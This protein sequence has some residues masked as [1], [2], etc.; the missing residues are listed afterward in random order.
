[1]KNLLARF[2]KLR[3]VS[4]L[5]ALGLIS[6][7]VVTL[8]ASKAALKLASE[9]QQVT[10]ASQKDKRPNRLIE[11]KS[12]YLLQHAYNPVDWFPWGEEAFEKARK[13]NK[14]IFL[15]IGYSTCFWCHQM[16]RHVFENED[17]AAMMNRY[18]VSIKVDREERPDVDRVYMSALQA[19]TGGGGWPMSMFLTP[20]LKPFYGATYIPPEQFRKLIDKIYE[21]WTTDPESIRQ[22]S[23]R[24]TESLKQQTGAEGD[25]VALEKSIGA[26]GFD[27]FRQTYDRQYAGFGKGPKFPHPA[28]FN[29]LLRYYYRFGEKEALQMTLQTLRRMAES[30]MY[31]HIGGG[32][33]RYSVDGQWRVP[34]FE[35]ML[36]DQ[37]QLVCSYLDAYQITRDEFYASI[38]R[39]TLGYVAREMT[40]KEGGFYSAEDAESAVDPRKPE[41]KEE[42]AFYI[43]TKEEIDRALGKE[44]AEVFN[45]AY[46]VQAG[47]N[48]LADPHSVFAGKNILYLA[49]PIS[50]A[51]KRFQK[52]PAE[53]TKL[54]AESRA[55]LFAA[56]SQRPRPHL[57]DKVLVSWN[58]LMISAFARASRVLD[59]PGYL[60]AAQRSAEFILGKL[61]DPRA[62]RLLRR[63]RAGEARYEANLEDYAFF[64]MGLLDLYE[65][66]PDVRW[67]KL[68]VELNE[69]QNTLL[70][71]SK[72]GGFFDA[73]GKDATLLF[74]T[75]E[76]YDGAEPAG[77]SIATLNL[78]RLAQMTDNRKWREMADRTLALFSGQLN[79]FPQAMPQ[80]LA[81][82]DYHLDKPKQII[83]AGQRGK[84]DT[85]RMLREAHARYIPNKIIL[86]AGGGEGQQFLS[87]YLPFIETVKMRGGKATAY[88]C[89]NYACKLPTSDLSVMAKL[90]R[91]EKEK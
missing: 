70:Y 41:E 10:P 40:G 66:S 30:G 35:K 62:E 67:L 20:D 71:D 86:L 82:L 34:H 25:S 8:F 6:A 32:F 16:E 48:A 11:E 52:S 46:G 12:P 75:K 78:L 87:Q 73:P 83:I 91:T 76:D 2:G 60:Q 54:L 31:D 38:A 26:K 4:G 13:E 15:S 59:D 56:R 89:E 58:G 65:A 79:E 77:N 42:G 36:Y 37:A 9:P 90:L 68:A 88:I 64:T 84:E 49:H 39:E 23:H 44:Q 69:R 5:L 53:V 57:D 21:V 7:G 50:D 33:H 43:W 85:E 19:M 22:P 51:A 1:M 3:L 80:M 18:F 47:D 72:Q 24:L 28:T 17:L 27:Q 55:R 29:F 45:Y 74:R 63:Y 81:S 14:L 61:Y